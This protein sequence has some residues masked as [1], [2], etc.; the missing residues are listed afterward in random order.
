[1]ALNKNICLRK[2]DSINA[3]IDEVLDLFLKWTKWILSID[4]FLAI[5]FL[6][7]LVNLGIFYRE[8]K[9][10]VRKKETEIETENGKTS[11][12]VSVYDFK[13]FKLLLQNTKSILLFCLIKFPY[14][15]SGSRVWCTTE[16]SWDFG[17][18]EL[19]FMVSQEIDLKPCGEFVNDSQ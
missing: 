5:T 6:T 3:C 8:V 10:D 4:N 9:F 17:S 18:E 11:Y 7:W 12:E 15:L 1:M 13:V 19:N 16:I 14:L 2:D